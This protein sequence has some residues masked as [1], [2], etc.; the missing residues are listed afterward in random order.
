VV[1]EVRERLAG[2]KQALQMERF[3]PRKL[4]ELDV[5]TQYH[6]KITYRFAGLEILSDSE[7]TNR[8]WKN[9]KVNTKICAKKNLGL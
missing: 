6:I 9:I 8:A 7:D 2:S 1:A 3:K 4:N 5:I